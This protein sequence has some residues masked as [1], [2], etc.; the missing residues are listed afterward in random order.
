MPLNPDTERLLGDLKQRLCALYGERLARVV[1][2]GSVARGEDTPHSDVDVLVVLHGPVDRYAENG[3]LADIV[4]NF[5]GQYR[6]PLSPVVMDETTFLSG[7]WP[8]L[9]TVREDGIPL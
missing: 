7:D 3:R 4:L 1:L 5:M 6:Q 2:F 8:L 9:R